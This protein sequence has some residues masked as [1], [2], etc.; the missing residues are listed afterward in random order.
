MKR[1]ELI[2]KFFLEELKRTPDQWRRCQELHKRNFPNWHTHDQQELTEEQAA[3]ELVELRETFARCD[4]NP[5]AALIAAAQ[6]H[7]Q[8]LDNS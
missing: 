4:A 3:K 5:V 2:E 8:N 1:V 7:A 6:V